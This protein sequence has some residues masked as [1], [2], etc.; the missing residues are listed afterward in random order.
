MHI[1]LEKRLT[2][3]ILDIGGGGEGVIGQLYGKQVTAIDIDPVELAEAPGSHEKLVMDA[4]SLAFSEASFD[5]VTA[6]YAFLFFSAEQQKQAILEAA[7]V[8]KPGGQMWIWDCQVDS[9][10]PEPFLTDLIVHLPDRTVQTTYGVGKL[11]GQSMEGFLEL[12]AASGLSL[13]E[14]YQREGHFQLQFHK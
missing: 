4:T 2:G 5:A 6:F 14:A 10:Y 12:C 3:R 7:R 9:A 11:E 8:L 1:V 13:M